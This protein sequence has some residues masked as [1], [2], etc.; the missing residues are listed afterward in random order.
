MRKLFVVMLLALLLGVGI[1]AV[2]ET[3]PGYVLVAYGNYTVETSLWVGLVLLAVFTGAVYLAVRLLRR[4]A[5]GQGS[6]VGWIDARR[7]RTSSRLTTR[8]LISY[9]EGNWSKARRQLLRGARHSEAPLV[10]YLMAA[11]ASYRLG[12]HDSVRKYLSAAE[13]SDRDAAVAVELIHAELRLMSGEY[14]QALATLVRARNN[15]GRHPQVL[16][17][18]QRA[19]RGLGDWSA[20][21]R[22]LPE[23]RKYKVLPAA[24]LDALERETYSSLLAASVAADA[25]DSGEPVQ[26]AWQQLP[27]PLRQDP[28][29]L[30]AYVA[31]LVRGSHHAA[32]EKVILRALKQ[33]WDPELVSQYGYVCAED[34]AKQLA[35]AERW[36]Q[37]HTEDAQL[38]L[39]LGRLAARQKLWG[40]ARDYFESSYRLKP[41]A[42]VCAELGRLLLA[43]GEPKVAGGYYREGLQLRETGLPELPMP[44]SSVTSVARRLAQSPQAR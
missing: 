43:L 2:I 18:L 21:A 42:E 14:Q 30:R 38:L 31:L 8:G 37:A 7:A 11:S 35:R 4:L 19:H 20:L 34:G 24:S 13:D 5:G 44:E 33:H 32:A 39:C 12:D 3:D 10:N 23:L 29:V 28:E 40:K 9:T 25:G 17:L 22:L 41:T 26:T 15:P 1:I 36:L 16:D 27:A 6:L